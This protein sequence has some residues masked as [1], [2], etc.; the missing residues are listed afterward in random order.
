[1]LHGLAPPFIPVTMSAELPDTRS[2]QTWEDAFQ[3]PLPIVRGI[4]K[5]LRQEV[6]GNQEKL[7]SLVGYVYAIF[8]I[9]DLYP[10]IWFS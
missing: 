2:F 5:K 9:M 8:V 3:Y 10:D 1:V 4:E 7:R 6:E